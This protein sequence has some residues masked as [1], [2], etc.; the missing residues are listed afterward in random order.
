MEMEALKWWFQN[1]GWAGAYFCFHM[2]VVWKILRFMRPYAH[3]YAEAQIT[4]THK[5]AEAVDLLPTSTQVALVH[6]DVIKVDGKID[7]LILTKDSHGE[8]LVA[9]HD[10]V[11]KGKITHKE[12]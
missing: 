12:S 10:R 4:L 9:I 3:R 7:Q 2:L 6:A 11:V 1:Y 8:L 5:L